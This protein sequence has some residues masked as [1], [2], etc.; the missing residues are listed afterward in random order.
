MDKHGQLLSQ[1]QWKL[2]ASAIQ[3]LCQRLMTTNVNILTLQRGG[4]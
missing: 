2:A 4:I 1:P 3:T